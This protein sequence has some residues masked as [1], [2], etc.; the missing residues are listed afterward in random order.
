[1]LRQLFYRILIMASSSFGLHTMGNEETL[2]AIYF[3]DRMHLS[4]AKVIL[5]GLTGWQQEDQVER[6]RKKRVQLSWALVRLMLELHNENVQQND[7]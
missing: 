4:N 1:M 5:M 7:L 2:R 6:F 3:R